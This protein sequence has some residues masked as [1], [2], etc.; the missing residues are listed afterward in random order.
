M[1]PLRIAFNWVQYRRTL[2]ELNNLSNETLNDIGVSRYQ[3]RNIAA[4][5]F[6]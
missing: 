5:S 2:S 1:N 4:R 3:I 6:R